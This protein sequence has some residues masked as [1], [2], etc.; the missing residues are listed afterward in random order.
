M[1][2]CNLWLI[3]WFRRTA[4]QHDSSRDVKQHVSNTHGLP[5]TGIHCY[6]YSTKTTK[7]KFIF[8]IIKSDYYNMYSLLTGLWIFKVLYRYIFLSFYL[9]PCQRPGTG[10]YWIFPHLAVVIFSF[11]TVTHW[12]T[13]VFP[14][15][16]ADMCT[17]WWGVLY[18]FW[19]WWDAVLNFFMNFWNIEKCTYH[20]V[21]WKVV[22][23]N[24]R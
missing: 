15:Y 19:H 5:T 7:E 22:A 2:W 21:K 11:Q 16:F 9:P 23:P 10:R 12:H 17:I 8:Q 6:T 13:A 18:S 20:M 3:M 24:R 1:L 14:R 4:K